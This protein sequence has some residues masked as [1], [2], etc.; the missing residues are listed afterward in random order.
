MEKTEAE[1]LAI[2]VGVKPKE[3]ERMLA[4]AGGLRGLQTYNW[5]GFKLTEKQGDRLTAF[6]A[7]EALHLRA[8]MAGKYVIREPESVLNFF[9]ATIRDLKRETFRVV[10]LDKG[11]AVIKEVS[12]GEGTVDQMA[13]HP[14]EIV[15]QVIE[16]NA[17][18][19]VLAH[20][21][22]SGRTEPSIQDRELTA[23]MVDIL[24]GI[25][26]KVLDHLIIASGAYFSF[27][28]HGLV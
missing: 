6:F 7:L 3:A 12:L 23:R 27:R 8:E 22:P 19:V 16:N 2:V 13:V 15:R 9:K 28:E 17:S 20:N 25:E 24:K 1:I 10:L 26:V 18:A 21:H 11:N 14:R 5:Q 4:L